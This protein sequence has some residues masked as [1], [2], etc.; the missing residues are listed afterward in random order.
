MHKPLRVQFSYALRYDKIRGDTKVRTY[1]RDWG[2]WKE[3]WTPENRRYRW[4][5]RAD[6]IL[7][8]DLLLGHRFVRV[9]ATR[10]SFALRKI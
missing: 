6:V 2:G 1:Q 9:A 8:R 7:P 5:R 3:W 4:N 10:K